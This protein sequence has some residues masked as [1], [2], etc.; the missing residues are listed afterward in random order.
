MSE[1]R[2]ARSPIVALT[3]ATG[4]LGRHLL[5]SLHRGGFRLRILARGSA[6]LAADT[7]VPTDVIR[8]DLADDASLARLV[9]DAD[10]VIHAAGLTRA[11]SRRDF[12]RVNRDGAHRLAR[13]ADRHAPHAHLVGISSLAARVP[14]LSAYAESKLAGEAALADAFGGRLTI[15]RPPVIY[16]PWDRATLGIFRAAA[17]PLVPM[18]GPRAARIA[19]IHAT[20]AAAAIVAVAAARHEGDRTIHALAD[21]NPAGYAPRD[22]LAMAAAA[23]GRE[24]RFVPVPVAAVRAAGW[25]A[26]LAATISRRPAVFGPGK[27]R[28]MVYGA[29]AV[30]PGERLPGSVF[31]PEID[32][33]RGF[34]STVAWYRQAGWLGR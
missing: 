3:G 14:S 7:S 32:L 1:D 19:M 17:L 13:A 9:A 29:W 23:L 15:L 20:D 31:R 33:R 4:F 18:P 22:I 2:R 16:G 30:A 6:P 11:G 8:G 26:G 28:E 25:V 27:A 34:A 5:A 24:P 21:D 10:I 12:M